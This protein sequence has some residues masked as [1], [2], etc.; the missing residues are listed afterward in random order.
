MLRSA[1]QKR[2]DLVRQSHYMVPKAKRNVRLSRSDM[3]RPYFVTSMKQCA[4]RTK[5]RPLS[6]LES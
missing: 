6:A 1:R 3:R 2:A 5:S 4:A